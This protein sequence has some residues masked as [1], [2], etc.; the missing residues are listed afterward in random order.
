MDFSDLKTNAKQHMK[1][2]VL[3]FFGTTLVLGLIL[4]VSGGTGIGPLL[5]SGV[6]ELGT[7]M[8]ALEIIRTEKTEFN[9]GF[10]GFTQFGSACIAGLVGTIFIMLW[11]CLFI[12]PGIIAAFRYS[13]TFYILADNPE[14][15]GIDALNKSKEMM[16]GHKWEF[17]LLQ[18]SFIGWCLLVP[19]TF[20]LLLI[21][22]TPYM[23]TTTALYY[24]KLKEQVASSNEE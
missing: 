8:L 3:V 24:E 16:K 18:L 12:I 1:G 19:F 9:T 7:V 5:L 6:I 17:F 2:N 22:L 4:S 23:E 11:S 20:G 10:K 15:S 21:W 14:M 13:M